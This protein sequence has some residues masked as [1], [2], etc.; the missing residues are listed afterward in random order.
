[1]KTGKEK[2][3]KLMFSLSSRVHIDNKVLPHFSR[4]HTRKSSDDKDGF[5]RRLGTY[6]L[7]VRVIELLPR[8]NQG[9]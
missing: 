3:R 6:N 1:M 4:G 7:S 5:S 8:Q 9:S 2:G